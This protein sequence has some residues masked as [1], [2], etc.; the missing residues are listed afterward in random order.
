MQPVAEI[1]PAQLQMPTPEPSRRSKYSCSVKSLG[2]L[3]M[4]IAVASAG[5]GVGTALVWP[6]L[7]IIGSGVWGGLLFYFPAGIL[8]LLSVT[9][10][11]GARKCLAIACLVMS[12]LSA[13]MA[14]G[15]VA[16]Y[17]LSIQTDLA[18]FR[19]KVYD[20]SWDL[21]VAL[22]SILVIFSSTEVFVSIVAA[23]YCCFVMGE[24]QPNDNT[25]IKYDATQVDPQG[26]AYSKPVDP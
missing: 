7:S 5:F 10:A 14:V 23:V 15:N 19:F 6:S 4:I 8:G 18:L 17:G 2:A 1:Q 21:P 16:V 13:V 12:I 3:Q 24:E 25:A 20:G 26:M 9:T 11:V 22:D